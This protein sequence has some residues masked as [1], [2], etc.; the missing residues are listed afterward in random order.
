MEARRWDFDLSDA[1]GVRRKLG[2]PGC[3]TMLS[4]VALFSVVAGGW[5]L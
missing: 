2:Q 4:G 5:A 1:D 3:C